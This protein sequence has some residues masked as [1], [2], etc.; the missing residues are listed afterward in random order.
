MFRVS[1]VKSGERF[2]LLLERQ[3]SPG[4][5]FE[6]GYFYFS[7][8]SKRGEGLPANEHVLRACGKEGIHGLYASE[9]EARIMYLLKNCAELFDG[10][11]SLPE[12]VLESSVTPES[13]KFTRYAQRGLSDEGRGSALKAF[14]HDFDTFKAEVLEK[15]SDKAFL[16]I[17]A[18]DFC[19]LSPDEVMPDEELDYLQHGRRV[20][21]VGQVKMAKWFRKQGPYAI[22]FDKNVVHPRENRLDELKELLLGHP[23]SVLEGKAATGKTVLVRNLLYDLLKEN[24]PR[25]YYF[26]YRPFD[27]DR[28]ARAINSI[29]GVVVLEDMHEGVL[30]FQRLFSLLRRHP[31]RH[32]LFT[33]RSN[34]RKL[35]DSRF[36]RLD[37]L[38]SMSLAVSDLEMGEIIRRFA[39]THDSPP[40]DARLEYEIRRA[41]RGSL[42]L[43]AYI[44]KGFV[45]SEGCGEA[46]DWAGE[47]VKQ[48]LADLEKLNPYFPEVLV[49]LSG[50]SQCGTPMA[51]PFL[52]KTLGFD[53]KC[54]NDLVAL[55]EISCDEVHEGVVFYG[56]WHSS[57]A[58]AYW[59]HGSRYKCRRGIVSYSEFL[60]AY[61]SAGMPNGLSAVMNDDKGEG[62]VILKRLDKMGVLPLAISEERSLTAV[63]MFLAGEG[64]CSR[65][66]AELQ[67]AIAARVSSDADVV[68]A[69]WCMV[70]G[71]ERVWRKVDFKSFGRNVLAAKH[72]TPGE[73]LLGIL[74]LAGDQAY[75]HVG[76]S[77]CRGL[78]QESV[79]E[80]IDGGDI[81]CA[82]VLLGELVKEMV[83]WDPSL[84]H[85]VVEGINVIALERRLRGIDN[86][87]K[88]ATI[89]TAIRSHSPG[90]FARVMERLDLPSVAR[91]LEQ[92]SPLED[93]EFIRLVLGHDRSKG[94]A[95]CAN[96]NRQLLSDN[97]SGRVEVGHAKAVLQLLRAVARASKPIARDVAQRLDAAKCASGISLRS[98]WAE[99]WDLLFYLARLA[100]SRAREVTNRLNWGL[101][102]GGVGSDLDDAVRERCEAALEAAGDS[103]W[104]EIARLRVR[105]T[106][107]RRHDR[108]SQQNKGS[109]DKTSLP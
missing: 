9:P 51:E 106:N 63:Q 4:A 86:I 11:Q 70:F 87:A 2:G 39:A 40:M 29:R 45:L 23:F 98:C 105:R 89:L 52:R 91:L 48:E 100:P 61:A 18:S 103:R 38:P 94:R 67:H 108:R 19:V 32:V 34:W 64:L 36:D 35:Q 74:K 15:D 20:L 72:L 76:R 73:P 17:N 12:R 78:D 66:S 30:T 47:G 99:Q 88:L 28:L 101:V 37:T 104:H 65:M 54:L 14:L 16:K 83:E 6:R 75:Q 21:K 1:V 79:T 53:M 95:L 92:S 46:R 71:G 56:L 85:K 8:D 82:Y 22:D 44:L 57:V 24:H 96:L 50:L 3:R 90:V 81:S 27:V 41:S 25:V 93:A 5:P 84:G 49:A 102:L 60:Y 80:A 62:H 55:G 13:G 97:L 107:R 10:V 68:Q 26:A 69:V 33:A 59:K 42:W 31:Q 109:S 77:I 58:S 43:L 7:T